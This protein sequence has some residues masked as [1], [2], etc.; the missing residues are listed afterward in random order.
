MSSVVHGHLGITTPIRLWVQCGYLPRQIFRWQ[1]TNS[2]TQ[3]SSKAKAK[4]TKYKLFDG[5]GL[6]LVVSPAGGKFW[7]WSYR[8]NGTE[9]LLSV[10]EYPD[11]GLAAARVEHEDWQK[12]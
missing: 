4:A 6:H 9:Q 1:E 2:Q 8:F 12:F 11:M 5:G 10:G 3:K 7:R